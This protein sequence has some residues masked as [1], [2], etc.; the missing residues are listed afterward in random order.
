MAGVWAELLGVDRVGR[1]D[2]FF[3]LGG[4]SLLA[5]RL[6]ARLRRV[7][8]VELSRSAICSRAPSC[9]ALAARDLP[10]AGGARERAADRAGARRGGPLPLSLAQQ[11]L[12]FLSRMAGA[13]DG[14]PPDR[15][16]RGS[17][18]RSTATR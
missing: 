9:A 2:D 3:E 1:H 17:T 10:A 14:L 12:W 4:H 15:R 18:A 5:M 13:S 6:L 11:R 16:R 7:L 8:D